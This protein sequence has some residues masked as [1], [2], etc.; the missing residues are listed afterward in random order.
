MG[1]RFVSPN[2]LFT[3]SLREKSLSLERKNKNM[4]FCFVLSS[5]IRTFVA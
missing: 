3:F 4:A 2:Y 5:L 1:W